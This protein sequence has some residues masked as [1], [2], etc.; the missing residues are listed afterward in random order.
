M[1]ATMLSTSTRYIKDFFTKMTIIIISSSK[2][3]N[4]YFMGCEA[5]ATHELYIFASL[6]AINVI[7]LIN[8]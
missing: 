1:Y 4:S 2:A 7:S 5:K 6:D 3:N 8:I